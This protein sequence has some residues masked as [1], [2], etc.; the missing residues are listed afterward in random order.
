LNIHAYVEL[1]EPGALPR[2]EGKASEI[3]L[4]AG[5]EA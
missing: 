4:N 2:Y 1:V 5:Y 3:K